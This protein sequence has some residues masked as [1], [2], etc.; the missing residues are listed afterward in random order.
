MTSFKTWFSYFQPHDTGQFNHS[1][2]L[3]HLQ[4]GEKGH[5]RRLN[6]IRYTRH[7]AHSRYSINVQCSLFSSP[8]M[9]RSETSAGILVFT[10]NPSFSLKRQHR[11]IC[12]HHYPSGED[13]TLWPETTLGFA[14]REQSSE[15]PCAWGMMLCCSWPKVLILFEHFALGPTNQ[16]AGPVS[17][18]AG[19]ET[20]PWMPAN[21]SLACGSRMNTREKIRGM[22]Q[23]DLVNPSL[24]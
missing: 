15:E 13:K 24:N 21:L 11:N 7:V 19:L 5:L 4:H 9:I 22:R 14:F 1:E 23:R 20:G 8:A 3:S 18:E 2:Q 17:G 10:S 6:I 12:F 16:G